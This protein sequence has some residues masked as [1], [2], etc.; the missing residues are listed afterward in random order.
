MKILLVAALA[1]YGSYGLASDGY[2]ASNGQVYPYCGENAID[3]DN[4]GWGWENEASCKVADVA[5]TQD[6]VEVEVPESPARGV[7]E[8]PK[9]SRGYPVYG[10][11][12]GKG[13]VG[14]LG[15]GRG[16]VRCN[17]VWAFSPQDDGW[18]YE[19]FVKIPRGTIGGWNYRVVKYHAEAAS[20]S[21]ARNKAIM[22]CA[23]ENPLAFCEE[24]VR[25]ESM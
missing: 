10:E 23:F 15:K 9:N 18:D 7:D 1:A 16:Q 24:N 25:V 12:Y 11:G 17:P 13:Y 6:P 5:D 8:M 19:A 20:V 4:D 3:P 14:V 2:L 21:C 22:L